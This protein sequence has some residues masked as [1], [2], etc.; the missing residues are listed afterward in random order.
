MS[1]AFIGQIVMFAGNFAPRGWALCQ[2]QLLSIAQ[3]SALFSI[4]G[5]TYGGDGVQTFALPD[6]RGR[7]PAGNGQGPGLSSYTLGQQGGVESVTLITSQI[8]AHSHSLA[9]NTGP[10]TVASPANSFISGTGDTATNDDGTAKDPQFE[11]APNALLNPAS[12][13]TI[14]GSQPHTNLHPYTCVNYVI[15]TSGVFPSRN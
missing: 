2:G 15:C 6:L 1:E 9:C 10:A 5:T 13:S 4:L 11:T 3:N 12:I 8:P 14:G 7:V